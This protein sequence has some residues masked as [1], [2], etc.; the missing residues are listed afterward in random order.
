[1]N[2]KDKRLAAAAIAAL[3]VT[4]ASA[5]ASAESVGVADAAEIGI[6]TETPDEREYMIFFFTDGGTEVADIIGRCGD[7]VP[8]P[9]EP[10][11]EG[12]IFVGWSKPIPSEMPAH[13]MCINAVWIKA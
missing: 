8:F 7:P 12:Y 5:A 3:L 1:M 10:V 9:E 13:D 11:K 4:S 2:M 6:V